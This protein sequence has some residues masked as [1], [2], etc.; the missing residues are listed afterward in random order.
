MNIN[1]QMIDS[2]INLQ[3]IYNRFVIIY[4]YLIMLVA[5]PVQQDYP[6]YRN[7]IFVQV[8]HLHQDI[9]VQ[10]VLILYLIL[11]HHVQSNNLHARKI[12]K[13]IH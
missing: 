4:I 9:Q 6:Y 10:Y 3:L 11:I 12:S 7:E 2:M 1:N 8:V 5:L 13:I